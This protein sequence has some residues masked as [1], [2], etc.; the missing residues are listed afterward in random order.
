[1]SHLFTHVDVR[2]LAPGTDYDGAKKPLPIL[3]FTDTATLGAPQVWTFTLPGRTLPTTRGRVPWAE[4]IRKGDAAYAEGWSGTASEPGT[5]RTL[6][7]G[8]IS[9]IGDSE[10]LSA[11]AYS[12][13][14]TVTVTSG[15]GT[16]TRDAVA[17]WMYYGSADGWTQARA[18][19]TADQLSGALD[20]ILAN[21]TNLVAFHHASWARGSAGLKDLLAYHFTALK[22]SAAIQM[23]L[24]M[25]EG[26]HWSIMQTVT[27]ELHEF[28]SAIRPADVSPQG[29]FVHRAAPGTPSIPR[30]QDGGAT[31]LIHRPAPFPFGNPDGSGN[32]SEW[33]RVRL[34]D[35]SAATATPTRRP[36]G[37]TSTSSSTS[38]VRNFFLVMPGIQ[39]VNDEMSF[40]M[41]IA[42]ANKASI[43]RHAY[44]PSRVRTNL[45]VDEGQQSNVLDFA[46]AL[47]WRHAG[48]HN[49]RDEMRSGSFVLPLAPN[50]TPGDR[51]RLRVPY[52]DTTQRV[53]GYVV[54]R[55]HR[56]APTGGGT[57][58]VQ[59]ERLL[60]VSVYD[61]PSW[62]V[63]GLELVKVGSAG[64]VPSA[65]PK[66]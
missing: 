42:L 11:G 4:I 43:Q 55:S 57:T 6:A 31:W 13:T 23:N 5:P 47:T 18:K 36:L 49:R 41:G 24:A 65:K 3:E 12:N 50:I 61:D 34:H 27:D 1:M 62:F 45:I 35:Y 10:Q 9:D 28:Y 59:V 22:A 37:Q 48:Q 15:H 7:H 63:K 26:N 64:N 46:R 54:A 40:S 29:G 19:L 58:T 39:L 25:Q 60:P 20:K 8:L 56:W 21:Y 38:A 44:S 14:T 52:G 17:W 33:R 51:I 32:V 2:T 16:L 30:G 53:E 66:A